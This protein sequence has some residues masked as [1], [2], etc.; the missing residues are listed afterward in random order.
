MQPARI[1]VVRFGAMG[2]ILHAMPAVATLRH[3]FPGARISWAVHPKWR[4]L[5][6]GGGLADELI[7]VNRRSLSS[8][9]AAWGALR[10]ERFDLVF[11]F[12]GLIQSA[13]VSRIARSETI[14]GFHVSQ[15]REK[16]AAMFYSKPVLTASAHVVDRNLEIAAAAGATPAVKEFALPP[17]RGEGVLPAGRFVLASPFAGWAS[18]QWPMEHYALLARRVRHELGAPLVLN[19]APAQEK[20]LREVPS[21]EVHISSVSGLIDATRRAAAVLGVDS[22]P[23]HLAAALGKP[24]V[25]LFGPTDPARNGPYSSL[26]TVL[27]LPG[28]KTTYERRSALDESLRGLT[29]DQ[30]FA[31]LK[32]RL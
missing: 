11:D 31:A 16:L 27:R 19:G 17:G 29:P 22:G 2:D 23:M 24:G 12:Q 1:L 10:R 5:L 32:D 20:A 28:V 14:Y 9:S 6:E 3:A 30:V 18:K 4:D 25:A 13:L 8:L 26:I 7:F 15:A 21:A